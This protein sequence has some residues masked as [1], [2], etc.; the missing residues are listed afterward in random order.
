[1]PDRQTKSARIIPAVILAAVVIFL[2]M[3]SRRPPKVSR[4]AP[5]TPTSSKPAGGKAK[6]Q[7]SEQPVCD[8]SLWQHVY[9]P[10]RLAVRNA[11]LRV[12]GVIESVRRERDGDDH[13]RIKL[14]SAYSN[15]IDG[16]NVARQDGD[17]VVEPVCENH[18]TQTD[19]K[20]ACRDYHSDIA[21]PPVG[22]HVAIVGSY[23]LDSDHGWM[24]IHPVTSRRVIQ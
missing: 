8:T 10:E 21:V 18:V 3:R 14:D 13:I 19:A 7:G 15:L 11:C 12:T 24:E 5:T 6:G 9:N 2:V 20:A 23:V 22:S 4:P 16:E 1:M 17:L